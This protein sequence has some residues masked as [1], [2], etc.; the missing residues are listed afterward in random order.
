VS[1][2][3]F[4]TRVKSRPYAALDVVPRSGFWLAAGNE[5][6]LAAW[7]LWM[8]KPMCPESVLWVFAA[9]SHLNRESRLDYLRCSPDL[10]VKL[11]RGPW[12]PIPA[13][14]TC[15]EYALKMSAGNSGSE[16]SRVTCHIPGVRE[17]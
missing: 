16:E 2:E 8:L 17:V 12:Y 14:S 5:V 6:G 10:C 9:Q 4:D 11:A 3:T 15:G 1:D 7:L 13:S